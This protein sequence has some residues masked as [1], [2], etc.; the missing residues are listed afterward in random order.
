MYE[1][2]GVKVLL[3]D[4]KTLWVEHFMVIKYFNGYQSIF[5]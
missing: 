1:P 2:D 3:I 5:F 4:F